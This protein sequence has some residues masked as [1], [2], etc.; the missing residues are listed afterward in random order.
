ML[1][2]L[3]VFEHSEENGEKL[4]SQILPKLWLKVLAKRLSL[5]WTIYNYT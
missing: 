4:V 5:E 2:G 3:L 1:T